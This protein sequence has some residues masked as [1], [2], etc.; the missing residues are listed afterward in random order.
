[1][2][3]RTKFSLVPD[4]QF[5]LETTKNNCLYYLQ[6]GGQNWSGGGFPANSKPCSYGAFPSFLISLAVVV[7][8]F[9]F[10]F[11]KRQEFSK[12]RRMIGCKAK[13]AR[14]KRPPKKKGSIQEEKFYEP[15]S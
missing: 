15:P 3:I 5:S 13:K 9:F 6:N 10:F 12:P 11:F 8:F 1:M 7:T 14:N 4:V 2:M